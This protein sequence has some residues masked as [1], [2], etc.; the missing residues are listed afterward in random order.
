MENLQPKVARLDL[1]WVK[2]PSATN[3]KVSDGSQP[4]LTFDL[5]LSESAGSRSLDRFVRCCLQSQAT[6]LSIPNADSSP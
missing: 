2:G 3:A 1:P 6:Q 4:P 5:S